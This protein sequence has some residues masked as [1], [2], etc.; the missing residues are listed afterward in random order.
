[1]QP[2]INKI[3][4]A[5]ATGIVSVSLI[6]SGIK[7]DGGTV[8]AIGSDGKLVIKAAMFVIPLIMIVVGYIV[9]LKKYKI[10]EEFYGEMLKDLEAR[11]KE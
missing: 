4:G 3:G 5:L 11:E 7:I 10:S 1:V 9:Y 8:D 6:L 2:F